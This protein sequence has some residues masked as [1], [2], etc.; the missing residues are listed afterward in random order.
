MSGVIVSYHHFTAR[1]MQRSPATLPSCERGGGSYDPV[2][3]TA[4]ARF[5]LFANPDYF[6]TN[7]DS[8]CPDVA[9]KAAT[10][11]DY[12][13]AWSHGDATEDTGRTRLGLVGPG[14]RHTGRTSKVWSDHTD[15]RP[16]MLSLVGLKDRYEWLVSPQG[17]FSGATLGLLVDGP[18]GCAMQTRMRE[19][20]P[21]AGG[22][23]EAGGAL[24]GGVEGEPVP[25]VDRRWQLASVE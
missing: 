14:V 7:S 6:M 16:T 15:I 23:R 22:H 19:A 13:F 5:T 9:P 11:V 20:T 18:L 2:H 1:L 17:L 25:V 12:H 10:C 24:A 8:N 3:H 4:H 21:A